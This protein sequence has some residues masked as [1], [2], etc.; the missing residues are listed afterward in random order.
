MKILQITNNKSS[1]SVDL[2]KSLITA[3]IGNGRDLCKGNEY[4]LFR[5]SVI[6]PDYKNDQILE[7]SGNAQVKQKKECVV[8]T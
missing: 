1:L 7:I 3:F 6:H 4:P 2:E 8:L 5:V